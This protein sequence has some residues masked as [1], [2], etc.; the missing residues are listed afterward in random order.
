[1]TRRAE[2][3]KG[4]SSAL[5]G[6]L[7]FLFGVFVLPLT[8]QIGHRPDHVHGQHGT[9]VWLDGGRHDHA[10][11]HA[12]PHEHR[13]SPRTDDERAAREPHREAPPSPHGQGALEHFGVALLIPTLALVPPGGTALELY[14]PLPLATVH[15]GRGELGPIQARAPPV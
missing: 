2:S 13:S 8:H 12:H 4:W 14:A 6:L 15:H 7:A 10:R 5:T 1:V 3:S 11:E 9:I